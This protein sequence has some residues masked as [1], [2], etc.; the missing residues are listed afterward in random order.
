VKVSIN[1]DI[2][3]RIYTWAFFTNP[4]G[5]H[6]LSLTSLGTN[7]TY[8]HSIYNCNTSGVVCKLKC[9]YKVKYFLVLKHEGIGLL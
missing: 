7:P 1:F 9:L 3:G 6:G 4:F 5:P 2:N 8:K